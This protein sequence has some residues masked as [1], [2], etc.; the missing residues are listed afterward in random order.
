MLL[1]TLD[2]M[3]EQI[4]DAA[5]WDTG[6]IVCIARTAGD[7]MQIICSDGGEVELAVIDFDHGSNGMTLISAINTCAN[8]HVPLLALTRP[9]EEHADC[10]ARVNGAV[11]CLPKPVS[12]AQMVKAII[13]C[14]PK[15][16]LA[17]A[18]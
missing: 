1:L 17:Q 6:G 15:G 4:M 9:G 2:P 14:R 5:L 10:M 12:A 7:A 13:K 16:K 18:A 11:E 8:R 3:V